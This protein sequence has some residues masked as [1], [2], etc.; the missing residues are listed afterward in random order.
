MIERLP[1]DAQTLHA[2]ALTMLLASEADRKWSHLSGSFVT[3]TIKGT[4]YVYFQYS[5]PGGSTRQLSIGRQSD[6]ISELIASYEVGRHE[7]QGDTRQLDRLARLLR[8]AG[9]ATTPHAPARV[10][11]A[12]ADAG[13]FRLGG[14][15]VGSYGFLALGNLLGVRW[16]TASWRTQDVDIASLLQVAVPELEADVPATLDS[17]QMGFVPV[18]QLD[19]RQ[20]STSFRVRGKPLRVDLITPGSEHDS[21]PVLIPRLRAAAA[22]IKHLSLVMTDAQPA[23]TVDGGVTL[24]LVPT[25]ARFA[26]HKLFISQNRSVVQQTKSGKDLHQAALLLEVLAADRPEDLELAAQAFRE[27]GP[28]VTKRLGRGLSAMVKRWP[29]AGDGERIVREQIESPG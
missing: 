2:E 26:L 9:A 13:V 17:L 29:D 19:S 25:P 3:K 21:N 14:V 6:R 22:P 24:I 16:P 28:T 18:P 1:E 7:R 8:T 27:S 11:R 20:P 23:A 5:E 4:G 15:L 10:L 12:L